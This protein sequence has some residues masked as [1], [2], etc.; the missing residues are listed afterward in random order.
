MRRI[1][2]TAAF[3]RDYKREKKGRFARTVDAEL[4]NVVAEL[5]EDRPLPRRSGG[6][7]K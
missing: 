1:R 5:A 2:R 6:S 3:K 7:I 4:A